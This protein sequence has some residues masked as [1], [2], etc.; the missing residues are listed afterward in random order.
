MVLLILNI[1]LLLFLVYCVTIMI[2]NNKTKSY[3]INDLST[4]LE[5]V[6]K[7]LGGAD[8]DRYPS[9]DDFKANIQRKGI[10]DGVF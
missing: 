10:N 6:N 5:G 9:I 7:I 4:N 3:Y 8:S 2:K 1:L